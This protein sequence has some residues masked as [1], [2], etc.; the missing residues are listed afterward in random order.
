MKRGDIVV[1]SVV[2]ALLAGLGYLFFAVER[3]PSG[4][5][6]G[7]APVEV[8]GAQLLEA[9]APSLEAVNVVV[10]IPVPYFATVHESIGSA[11]GP[12]VGQSGIMETGKRMI[13]MVAQP[14]LTPGL[15]YIV[16]IHKDDG[17][18]AFD[19]ATDFP[20]MSGGVVLRADVVAP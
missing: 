17:D 10:D 6:L 20:M 1:L 14:L 13:S 3:E 19:I 5:E 7:Y 9:Y 11:P 15:T 4:S 18:G 8:E 16:L 2:V 12:M